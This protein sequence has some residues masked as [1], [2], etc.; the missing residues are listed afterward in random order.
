M[1]PRE[2]HLT[3]TLHVLTSI[4]WFGA[5]AVFLV[6]A[7]AGLASDQ[8]RAAAA[9]YVAMQLATRDM[10]I[11][12]CLASLATGAVASLTSRWGLVR[13]YWVAVKLVVTLGATLVLF[14]HARPIAMLAELAARSDLSPG[15]HRA[16]RGQLVADAAAALGVLIV[17]TVLGVYKPR[18]VTRYG[19]RAA[20]PA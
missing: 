6:L 17:A 11:P 15:D 12:L 16:I 8:P 18:G 1:A 20:V 4:G 5:V 2:R 3:L 14:V 7:I 13:H 19:R 9:V 10:I